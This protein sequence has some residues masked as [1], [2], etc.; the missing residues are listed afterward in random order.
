MDIPM[1]SNKQNSIFW[2]MKKLAAENQAI[3]L[4][5]GQTEFKCPSYLTE[6]AASYIQNGFNNFSCLEG[7]KP[8]REQISLYYKKSYNHTYNPESEITI[9]SGIVQAISTVICTFIKEDDEVIIFEPAFPTYGPA[10]KL[11]GGKPKFISLKQPDFHIDW[12]EVV[13]TITSKTKMIVIDSPHNPTGKVITTAD[14][15]QL[16]KLTN[17]TNIIILSDETF[18]NM[19]YD[20]LQHQSI[21]KYPNLI[22]RSL[23][24]SS[25]GPAFNI[26]G[27]N[28]AWCAGPENLMSEFKKTYEISAFN[29]NAPLQYALS[30]YLKSGV[31]YNEITEL[32]QGKRNYFNRLM[33]NSPFKII[34]TEGSYF[35]LLDYSAISDEP[36]FDFALK[37]ITKA[38]VATVPISTFYHQKKNDFLLRI[39]FA[40]KNETLEK[41]AQYLS[42]FRL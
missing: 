13:M 20:N 17:G 6:L 33:K 35:Q 24:V 34:P 10:V 1:S 15:E 29:A 36:D 12:E 9:T 18:E 39:C 42:E 31:D 3:D 27:W 26:N 21:S 4:T 8:F 19:C 38:K 25:F 14:L 30:D 5:V 2:E 22:S 28:L 40:K 16:Q 32:Y 11:S 37:L 23:I 7:I 41:A